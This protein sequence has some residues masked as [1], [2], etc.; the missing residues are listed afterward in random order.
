MC[1]KWLIVSLDLER[2]WE[3]PH[4][5]NTL[6]LVC[7]QCQ[8][9][10]YSGWIRLKSIHILDT[11]TLFLDAN[12]FW[13]QDANSIP[14]RRMR[15][16][17]NL[18]LTAWCA[19]GQLLNLFLNKATWCRGSFLSHFFIPVCFTGRKWKKHLLVVS[20]LPVKIDARAMWMDLDVLL[21]LIGSYF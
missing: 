16:N 13:L 7:E 21:T 19:K 8:Y 18:K 15:S 10:Q 1:Y 6:L 12:M 20:F 11:W 2:V 3:L 14:A 9:Y 5:V 17:Q 4:P